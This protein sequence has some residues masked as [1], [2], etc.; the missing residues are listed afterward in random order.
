MVPCFLVITLDLMQRDATIRSTITAHMRKLV[1]FYK[2][3]Y[4]I[5]AILV[6]I[7]KRSKYKYL[8]ASSVRGTE[9]HTVQIDSSAC[10]SSRKLYPILFLHSTQGRHSEDT[11]I[12]S[13]CARGIICRVNCK[14]C[15]DVSSGTGGTK[16]GKPR[17]L[18]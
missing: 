18:L 15:W 8:W 7:T 4:E 5:N 17:L 9:I 6:H 10:A 1:R 11:V 12:C 3:W 16:S 14:L 2:L 13:L